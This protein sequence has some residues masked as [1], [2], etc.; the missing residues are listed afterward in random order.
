MG[1]GEKR[2]KEKEK[3]R[4]REREKERKR[5]KRREREDLYHL[6]HQPTKMF[7]SSLLLQPKEMVKIPNV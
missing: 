5:R 2:E 4:K 6:R 1:E 3:K 7:E